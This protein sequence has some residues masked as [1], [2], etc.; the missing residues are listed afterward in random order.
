MT[1]NTSSPVWQFEHSVDCSAPRHF[2]WSH[3]TDIA[4][5]NDPPASFHLDGPFDVGARLTTSLP[6]QTLHSLIREVVNGSR[7]DAAIIDMQLPGAILSFQWKFESLSED[8][9]RITQRLTLSGA[10]A[11]ALVAQARMLEKSTPEGMEKL[12]A[13]IERTM[14]TE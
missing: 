2:A 1:E 4:N 13:A 7:T 14:K 6:G 8:R 10:D 9:T 5:W 3:W 11:E 12:A